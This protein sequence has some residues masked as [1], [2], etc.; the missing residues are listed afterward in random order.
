MEWRCA[1]CGKPHE[2]NDP[3]C[4]NCGH[5]EF[6]KA[7]VPVAPESD[8]G[9]DAETYHVWE[10]TECGNDHPKHTPPCDRCGNATLERREVTYDEEAVVEEM[11]GEDGTGPS[12]DVSYLDALDLR[13]GL[14]MLGVAA[15]VVVLGLG[16]LGIVDVPGLDVGPRAEA[17]AP[18]NGTTVGDHSLDAIETAYVEVVNDRRAEAGFEELEDDDDLSRAAAHLNK[19]LVRER[20]GDERETTNDVAFE[21]MQRACEDVEDADP[22]PFTVE[23]RSLP[24]GSLA[25]HDS[26][27]A[28]AAALVEFR[29]AP[30]SPTRLERIGVDVHVAPDGTVFVTEITC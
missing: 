2:E 30:G 22:Q 15:L 21:L 8:D 5:G 17:T 24:S 11:L 6:E 16:Y 1:W 7:V 14:L 9:G 28:A 26:E 10:C 13:L 19:R 4:D 23:P 3:P 25:G 12:A 20:V 27:T 29:D 18:G